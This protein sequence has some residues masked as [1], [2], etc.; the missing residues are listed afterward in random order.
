MLSLGR[1]QESNDSGRGFM[2]SISLGAVRYTRVAIT[3]HWLMAVLILF[4]L[5]LGWFMNGFPQ[6]LHANLVGAH[7]QSGLMVLALTIARILWRISH[8]P[9]AFPP[10]LHAWERLSAH[11]AH[12]ALYAL[13]LG[14]TVIGW[15]IVS[16]RPP[17]PTSGP[18]NW[19]FHIPAIGPISHLNA[20]AQKKAHQEFV[21]LHTIGGWLFIG[22]L[23]L[24]ILGALKHQWFDHYPELA[25]MGLG[26]IPATEAAA[27]RLQRLQ[28]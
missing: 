25:R 18:L 3:L 20:V 9:P 17:N 10:G 28:Q 24:H 5:S 27:S 16:A 8:R 6:P 7:T 1:A 26:R 21:T 15:C 22:V 2:D 13:M 11:A 19:A 23:A 14:M 12:A 4:N